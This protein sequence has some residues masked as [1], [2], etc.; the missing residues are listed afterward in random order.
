MQDFPALPWFLKYCYDPDSA[1][2]DALVLRCKG[3]SA[4]NVNEYVLGMDIPYAHIK[5]FAPLLRDEAKARI[6]KYITDLDTVLWSVNV[7][8]IS[9]LA[10]IK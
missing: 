2:N 5:Q 3:L 1:P 9:K 7:F 8:S 4:E 6:A 10:I